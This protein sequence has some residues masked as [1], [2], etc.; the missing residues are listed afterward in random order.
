LQ[1]HF[2]YDG[3]GPSGPDMDPISG[4]TGSSNRSNPKGTV[5]LKSWLAKAI[6]CY[7]SLG[8]N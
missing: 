1:N 2:F 3:S 7:A 4:K 6:G 5:T 8:P